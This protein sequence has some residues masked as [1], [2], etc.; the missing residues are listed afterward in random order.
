MGG[1][2]DGIKNYFAPWYHVKH[3]HSYTWFEGMNYPYGENPV[4]ADAQPLISNVLRFI[5]RNIV[6]IAD[7]T[8]GI[9]NLLLVLSVLLAAFFLFLIFRRIQ[10]EAIF[11]A[12]AASLI[13]L[14]SPQILKFTGHY[15][16]GYTF[17]VPLIWYLALRYFENYQFKFSLWIAGTIFLAAWVH[18][19]YLMISA[20]FL[21]AMWLFQTLFR[22]RDLSWGHRIRDF[23]LQIILPGFAFILILKLT[24]PVTDRP[25]N[26]YGFEEFTASW[27]TVFLPYS[28]PFLIWFKRFH[29]EMEQSWEGVAYVGASGVAMFAFFWFRIVRRGVKGIFKK[30]IPRRHF[31][32]IS[33]QSNL[34]ISVAAG[35]LVLVFASGF[36]FSIQPELMTD[37]FPPIKQFRSL[38]RFAWVFYYTWS[39]FTFYLIYLAF[40]AHRIKG[41]KILAYTFV[42]LPLLFL[43]AESFDYNRSLARRIKLVKVPNVAHNGQNSPW[44]SSIKPDRYAALIA[45]PYF[46]V[47][48]ENFGTQGSASL[49][50]AFEASIKTG[51]PLMN[52]MMSRTSLG[53]TWAS[54]QVASEPYSPLEILPAM[55]DDR[56][57]LGL[58]IGQRPTLDGA[59]LRPRPPF[60][61][62]K[63]K[64]KLYPIF[65]KKLAS[66]LLQQKTKVAD[67]LFQH[68]NGYATASPEP[69]L[70]IEDFEA[71]GDTDGYLKGKGK[72]LFLHENNTLFSGKLKV[73][74]GDTVILSL[75]VKIRA[76]RLAITMF[77]FE[78]KDDADK[79][80]VSWSYPSLNRSI[81]AFDGSWALCEREVIITSATH[82]CL[83]NV[84]RWKKRPKSLVVDKL[85]IRRKG[86]AIYFLENGRPISINNRHIPLLIS[87]SLFV[88]TP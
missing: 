66:T 26:P 8:V 28:I 12:I 85:M 13:A 60:I 73:N 36:P 40:R 41:R 21:S 54:L 18:P 30:W 29:I 5:S 48:S 4:F 19:Y 17:Y 69:V 62:Q 59:Y 39:V 74:P 82:R 25:Y 70:F 52:V 56:P 53:Q 38:G 80:N 9:L 10:V 67:T 33:L 68:K 57:V 49:P 31:A 22:Y 77:G 1:S 81:K 72:T 83:V 44:I 14:L 35:L 32:W 84:T 6:D 75:W 76:D 43:F 27:R 51:L 58:R 3:D 46:H 88:Q 78:E 65:L 37:F 15:A 64:I 34:A 61:Y 45:L 63:G 71:T 55:S 24:D 79:D 86:R 20:V 7:Y 16:L 11:A 87:D 50:Q 42:L 23:L 47:G 2:K